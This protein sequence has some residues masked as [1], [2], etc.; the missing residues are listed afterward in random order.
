MVFPQRN[1]YDNY[2][3]VNL[4]VQQYTMSL[5]TDDIKTKP[6]PLETVDV[7]EANANDQRYFSVTTI[8]KA[9]PSPALEYWSIK[10]AA[11]SA[12]DSPDLIQLMLKDQGRNEAVKWICGARYRRPKI[13][14]GADQL[15]TCVHKV[16][17]KYA[18]DGER[19][20]GDWI[21][22][23]VMSH[24]A[25]TVDAEKE[26]AV[27]HTMVDQFDGWCQRFSPTPIA[28]E[29][30]V[31][32]DTYRYAGTLDS[33]MSIDGVTFLVDFK[34]RREPLDNK[35]NEQRPYP[36]TALQLAAYRHAEV[37]PIV[38]ARRTEEFRRRYYLLSPDE[39]ETCAKVPEVDRAMCLI[40]T[41]SSCEAWPMRCD[42]EV[43]KY[44]LYCRENFRWLE[45]VSKRV[46]AP[47]ALEPAG[48]AT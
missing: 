9:I 47:H 35:G 21:E 17:E 28:A 24:A 16:C 45:Q 23:L 42:E 31:Y 15:G 22:Q 4:S 46:V 3:N 30:S 13:T 25:P 8:L 10:M 41:P 44:F 7:A 38:R 33:I 39:R 12:V 14:L 32:S 43:F 2:S 26:L 34:T 48:T 11:E 20:D 37:A 19:P 6:T 18:L 1:D 29:M 27:V 5:M 36:D 40:I